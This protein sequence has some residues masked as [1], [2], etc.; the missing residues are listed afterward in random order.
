MPD[1]L[2]L[3]SYTEPEICDKPQPVTEADLPTFAAHG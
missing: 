1:D 2:G 3:E